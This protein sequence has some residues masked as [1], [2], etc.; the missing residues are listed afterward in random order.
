[1]MQSK[2]KS[3]ILYRGP[4]LLDGQPIVA[5]AIVKSD[6]AK[7]GNMVQTYILREDIDPNRRIAEWV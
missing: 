4:S 7:T 2:L 6:N 1:M 3:S 5:I